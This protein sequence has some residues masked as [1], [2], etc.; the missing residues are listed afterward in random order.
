MKK[1]LILLLF[2]LSLAELCFTQVMNIDDKT[3][4]VTAQGWGKNVGDTRI[5]AIQS[6]VETV[7]NSML[8]TPEEHEKFRAHQN[9]FLINAEKYLFDYQIIRK[10]LQ[11]G[12]YHGK[13]FKMVM[14][15]K[16]ALNKEQLRKDL[17]NKQ[18]LSS[19][20]DLRKQLDLFSIMPY[21]DE[22][23]SSHAFVIK[24]DQVYAKI[25]SFLQN[26]HIPFI[27]EEE[28]KK[29]EDTEEVI[30]ME[31]SNT[32]NSGEE[33]LMLQLARNT[34]ADF[35]IKIIGHIDETSVEGA[36]C[37]KVSLSI[38]VF[39]VMT[40]E[41]IASQ[42]GFSRPLSLS[43]PDA[44]IATGIEE[45]VNSSMG[46]VLE[47]L[48]L[49]WKDYVKDGRPYKLVFYDYNFNEFAHIR[50]LLMELGTQV[51][52]LKKAG[53]VIA[54]LIWRKGSLDELMFDIPGKIDL[55]L[56]EDPVILG[57]T[58]RFFRKPQE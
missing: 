44:S 29:I 16:M 8:S 40:G 33:D 6:G 39:T 18:I 9:E 56:K 27:D 25:G 11:K 12:T 30:A 17:E 55:N 38:T 36:T 4:T 42:T 14:T 32:S 57:N 31:K 2:I 51:K 48:R 7:I 21:V 58:L 24:K 23:K 35:Y 41:N 5:D 13:K 26:Q 52:L 49:F 28:I 37:F 19:L 54:F 3:V 1:N 46:D 47:K 22:Q 45:A 34:L 10:I 43:S 50:T 20:N 53:N 15:I